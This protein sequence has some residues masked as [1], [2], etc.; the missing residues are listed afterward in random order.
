MDLPVMPPVKPMLAKSVAKI[1]PGM[2]YEA[3]WDGFRAIVFRDGDEV[4]L[5]SRT[6]KPLT[7]YFPELAEA[8]RERLPDRCVVDGE[9]VIAREGHLDFDALTERIHPA[10][11]RVRTL[12]ERTPASFVAFDL[13]ALADESLL[14]VP[15]TDR[16]KLLV[17]ALRDVTPP[18]HVAPATTDV[19]VARGWFEQYEGAGLDGVVAKPLDLR[20][21]QDER[22]MFKIKH[23][24]TADVVVAG[25]RLHK[26]GPVVG[27]L[28]LGLYD[29][30]GAL[31]HV[32]VSAAFPM[33]RRAELVEELEPLRMEDVSDHPW[34][35]WADEAAHASAR[36]PGAL[37]R[38]T[39]KKD[40]SWVPLRPERVAEVAYDHMENGQ[41]FRHTA[42]F[43]R[44]RPDRTPESCTYTQLEEPVRYDLAEI[45][46]GP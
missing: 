21:R 3:K 11:S 24:R 42:R 36:L 18:V 10:D 16:R 31:Q 19:E 45:L 4:E 1:P 8:L 44:W 33:K 20:Y 22:A 15:L 6:G 2:Q 29:A 40:L 28:L 5:G 38:W 39:G 13:L 41:R 17:R 23:E 43:R 32:G 30:Q 26:S 35:A 14:D 34:A 12:A 25:Y 37:S 9:I 7:R 27:S 46:G